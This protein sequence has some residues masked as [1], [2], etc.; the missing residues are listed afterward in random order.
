MSEIINVSYQEILEV[1]RQN[2]KKLFYLE[3]NNKYVLWCGSDNFNL[4]A[5]VKKGS[6]DCTDFETNRKAFCNKPVEMVSETVYTHDFSDNATWPATDNS[7]APISPPAGKTLCLHRSTVICDKDASFNG[8][9][10]IVA[11]WS[12][13]TEAC[14]A[15]GSVPTQYNDSVFNPGVSAGWILNQ[16]PWVQQEVN[17]YIYLSAAGVP[18]Y[19]CTIFEYSNIDELIA[20][21]EFSFYGN[22][23]IARFDFIFPVKLRSSKNERIESYA[24]NDTA[25]TTP[26][27][28][29]AR[30]TFVMGSVDEF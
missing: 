21:S 14:P 6:S 22:R 23:L 7:F 28:V 8:N 4:Y 5:N 2:H 1:R 29:P 15:V 27:G 19:A 24:S 18:E 10:L 12:G 26:N 9:N 17:Q 13:I 20:K 30:A 11:V 25:I 16:K 3:E